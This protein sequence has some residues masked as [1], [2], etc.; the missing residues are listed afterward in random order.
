[1][2]IACVLVPD[3]ELRELGEQRGKAPEDVWEDELR[4]LEGVG[5]ALESERPGEAYFALDGLRAIHGGRDGVLAAARRSSAA[6][7][8]IGVAP[9]RFAAFAAAKD[10]LLVAEEDLAPFLGGLPVAA[11]AP[12]LELG[13]R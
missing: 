9:T 2:E 10:E 1:M 4:R 7:L 6:P 12:R 3:H 8:R 13:E 11:L 5:A